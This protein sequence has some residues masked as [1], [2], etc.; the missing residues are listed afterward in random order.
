MP[1]KKSK[2]PC[3]GNKVPQGR[4]RYCVKPCK[5]GQTRKNYVCKGK[6]GYVL[7]ELSGRYVKRSGP[8]GKWIAG[9]GPAPSKFGRDTS[10]RQLK[11]LLKHGDPYHR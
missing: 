10:Y 2:K 7:N 1:P 4:R 8:T 9:K 6:A 5:T 3:K 11:N